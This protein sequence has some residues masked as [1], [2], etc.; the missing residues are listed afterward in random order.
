MSIDQERTIVTTIETLDCASTVHITPKPNI[1]LQDDYEN[2]LL[3]SAITYCLTVSALLSND[4]PKI[5][6]EY[7]QG[8][9]FAITRE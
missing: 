4:N 9:A 7:L 8:M 3:Q 2:Q 5:A 6:Q 1:M